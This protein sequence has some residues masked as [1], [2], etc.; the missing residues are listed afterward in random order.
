MYA[1]L[2]SSERAA[3]IRHTHCFGASTAAAYYGLPENSRSLLSENP[4]MLESLRHSTIA[5]QLSCITNPRR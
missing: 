3:Y 5:N 1:L 2:P 4:T